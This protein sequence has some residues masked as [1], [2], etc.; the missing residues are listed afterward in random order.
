M[1]WEGHIAGMGE[2]SNAYGMRIGMPKGKI[3]LGRP[4]HRWLDN[5][6][7]DLLETGRGG[8]DWI[9]LAQNRDNWRA[10]VNAVMNLRVP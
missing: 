6:K 10:P 1:S 2:K 5:I 8:V 9:G 7:I 4:R 3:L